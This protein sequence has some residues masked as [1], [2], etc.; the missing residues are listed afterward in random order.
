V[1]I[2]PVLDHHYGERNGGTGYQSAI[3][4]YDYPV[5]LQLLLSDIWQAR[6]MVGLSFYVYSAL[7]DCLCVG[8]QQIRQFTT[9]K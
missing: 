1:Y 5:L 9:N 8:G 6:K 3:Y 2:S 7:S 4:G